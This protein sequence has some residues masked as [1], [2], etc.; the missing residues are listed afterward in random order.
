MVVVVVVLEL[1][2]EFEDV[3]PKANPLRANES[4]TIPSV[5]IRLS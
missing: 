4:S 3:C 2:E 1:L 5:F